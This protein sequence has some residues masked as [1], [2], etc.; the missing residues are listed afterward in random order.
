M[1]KTSHAEGVQIMGKAANKFHYLDEDGL[2]T[3]PEKAKRITLL[4]YD[5]G[6]ISKRVDFE[7]DE[8]ETGCTCI[9]DA[10]QLATFDRSDAIKNLES[11]VAM[12]MRDYSQSDGHKK[13]H[14]AMAL[15]DANRALDDAL[16]RIYFEMESGSRD[17]GGCT[18][19]H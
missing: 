12:F 13:F 16:H 4:V 11:I 15:V 19:G 9:R 8:S 5:K 2:E 3:S 6:K 1:S 10:E 17:E 18:H 14:L 7:L